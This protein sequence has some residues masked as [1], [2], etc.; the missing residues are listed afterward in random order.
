MWLRRKGG[1]T[2]RYLEDVVTG[3]PIS[4]IGLGTWQFG[5]R[6]WGYGNDYASR[7][8]DLIVA[9][10][11][12]LGITL[13]DTAEAYG[14]GRSER[15]LG[16]A[17]AKHDLREKAF[18]ATKIFPLLPVAPVVRHR[19]EASAGRLGVSTI[20]LYQV[21]WPNPVIRDG[22]TMAGMRD[23]Q[24]TGVVTEVG[25]SNYSLDRWKDA[26]RAL[27]RRVLSNQ[28][29]FSLAHPE[30][31]D[32]MVPFAQAQG[33]VVIAWSPL[34][35][36][37][38]STRYDA[39]H[40]PT[41]GVRA[42]NSLFLDE[43]LTRAAGLLDTLRDVATTHQVTPAQVALAWLIHHPAVVA[44]PGASSIAQVEANAA[45]ADLDLTGGEVAEL[46]EQAR[47][48]HPVSGLSAGRQLAKSRLHR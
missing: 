34:A 11:A 48:F 32:E 20:D 4:R 41:G 29:Q 7:D 8:A 44:I 13:F 27:G 39:E 24:D 21:H 2:V 26:E 37:F 35:Q 38:L 17:V 28:V 10:A 12:D 47:R 43:N 16:A 6:E 22:T 31:L 15:I 45:A 1:F 42:M 33:R 23:L 30:P 40:R 5:S 19:A 46:T 3:K 25:V 36:G 14:M 18:I 9:R